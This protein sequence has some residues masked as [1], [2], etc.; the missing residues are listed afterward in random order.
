MQHIYK[1][2]LK[3][4]HVYY[5]FFQL[6]SKTRKSW[7]FHLT[8]YSILSRQMTKIRLS[9][10]KNRTES[11]QS[12]LERSEACDKTCMSGNGTIKMFVLVHFVYVAEEA[13]CVPF[14]CCNYS[15]ILMILSVK[16]IF[17]NLFIHFTLIVSM[18]AVFCCCS[19]GILSR[20]YNRTYHKSDILK[21]IVYIRNSSFFFCSFLRIRP[22]LYTVHKTKMSE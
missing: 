18:C 13:A 22:F 11:C 3:K 10:K 15:W 7:Q 12:K 14:Y 2:I 5:I 1:C 4:Y 9:K 19:L 16:H 8:L 20:T 6:A 21:D 17:T